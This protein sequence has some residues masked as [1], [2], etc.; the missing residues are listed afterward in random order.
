M[1]LSHS[2]SLEP[3][4]QAIISKEF[5]FISEKTYKIIRFEVKSITN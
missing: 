1:A 4:N 2:A 3:L 5:E